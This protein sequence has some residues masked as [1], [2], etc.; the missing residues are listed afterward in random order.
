[1]SIFSK[2][3]RVN[4]DSFTKSYYDRYLPFE[5][6]N[7]EFFRIL[8]NQIAYVDKSFASY[9]FDQFLNQMAAIKLE[10]FGLAWYYRFGDKHT[11]DNCVVTKKYLQEHTLLNIWED[12]GS[13]NS[14]A[15]KSAT[16]GANESKTY[17]KLPR[18]ESY[19]R[20]KLYI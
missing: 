6:P 10:C 9:D 12:L 20:N 14:E 5:E 7:L 15:A 17:S 3:V 11:V 18:K 8:K 1:M 2:K 16:Y 13:Y 19:E 4:I